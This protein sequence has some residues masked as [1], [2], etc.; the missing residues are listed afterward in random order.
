[1]KVEIPH[2]VMCSRK[3]NSNDIPTYVEMM[4]R[5]LTCVRNGDQ[6]VVESVITDIIFIY[7]SDLIIETSSVRLSCPIRPNKMNLSQQSCI[8][9]YKTSI[10]SVLMPV[11]EYM[12][13]KEHVYE[14]N[15]QCQ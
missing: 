15:D 5:T 12:C 13:Q 6:I 11:N 1:M 2:R 9:D 3:K 4:I 10:M 14:L 8:I 7:E